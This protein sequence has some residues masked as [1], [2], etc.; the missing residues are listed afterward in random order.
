VI[1]LTEP[2]NLTHFYQLKAAGCLIAPDFDIPTK[3]MM[4][5][6]SMDY[7]ALDD[8]PETDEDAFAQF[9]LGRMFGGLRNATGWDFRNLH[10][11]LYRE[12]PTA[13]SVNVY[14]PPVPS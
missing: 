4:H 6:R 2:I 8:F 3:Y 9:M 13:V 1:K 12:A 7:L 11:W 10:L 14:Y 5:L